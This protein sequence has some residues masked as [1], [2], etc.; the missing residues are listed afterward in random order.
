MKYLQFELKIYNEKEELVLSQSIDN[1][2]LNGYQVYDD[3]N[4][5][6]TFEEEILLDIMTKNNID[7][8]LHYY[9]LES[10]T[11]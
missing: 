3:S 4:F 9:E 10:I 8:H 11:N 6:E 5:T 2:I 1:E 7:P